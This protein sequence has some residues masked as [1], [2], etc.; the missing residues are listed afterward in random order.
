LLELEILLIEGGFLNSEEA[1]FGQNQ[2]LAETS[3]E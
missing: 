3:E 1:I 2:K